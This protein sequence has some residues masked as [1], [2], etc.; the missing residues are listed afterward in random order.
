M[1][2]RV[3]SG[4]PLV[5]GVCRVE[6]LRSALDILAI[7]CV[8]PRVQLC[9]CETVNNLNGTSVPAI[10]YRLRISLYQHRKT[11]THWQRNKNIIIK[12]TLRPSSTVDVIV[13]FIVNVIV[14][15]LF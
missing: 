11:F 2:Q 10:R 6:T 8:V 9:L 14:K 7:S 12:Y 13:T 1:V 15:M 5:F 3:N 4:R